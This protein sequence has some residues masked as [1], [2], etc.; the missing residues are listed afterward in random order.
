MVCAAVLSGSVGL[1]LD[2]S[3]VTLSKSKSSPTCINVKQGDK[4]SA[5]VGSGADA[6]GEYKSGGSDM[7]VTCNA[8]LM[9][10]AT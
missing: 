8:N 5:S 7:T 3:A 4:L 2:G 9:D 6:W 10:Y 1:K